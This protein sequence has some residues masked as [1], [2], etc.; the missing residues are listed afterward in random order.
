MLKRN[1]MIAGLQKAWW[2]LK[3]EKNG[4]RGDCVMG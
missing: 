4:G 1:E 2:E 3:W